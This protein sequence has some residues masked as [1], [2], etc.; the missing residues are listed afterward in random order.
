LNQLLFALD[1]VIDM[2]SL[3]LLLLAALIFPEFN[4]F[5]HKKENHTYRSV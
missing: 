5:G 3:R 2:Q 1:D 4:F